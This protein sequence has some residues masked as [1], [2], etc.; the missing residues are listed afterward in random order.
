MIKLFLGK[1][2]LKKVNIANFDAQSTSNIRPST[3]RLEELISK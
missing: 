2:A 1:S 3:T